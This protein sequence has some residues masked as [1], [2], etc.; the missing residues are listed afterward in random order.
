ML[1]MMDCLGFI[2]GVFVPHLLREPERRSF[3]EKTMM[4]GKYAGETF[5]LSDDNSALVS[6][7]GEISG[8][9]ADEKSAV[10]AMTYDKVFKYQIL[11]T[12]KQK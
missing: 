3:S 9:S 4:G 7:D 2:D 1:G 6:I 10:R 5:Y 12:A 11:S 8:I